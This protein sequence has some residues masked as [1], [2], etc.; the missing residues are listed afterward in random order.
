MRPQAK[1]IPIDSVFHSTV[2]EYGPGFVGRAREL[3]E[4][5][6]WF[7]HPGQK[8]AFIAGE[9]GSGIIATT[10]YFTKGAREFRQEVV[11]QMELADYVELQKW[12][13]GLNAPHTPKVK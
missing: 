10:S 6:D 1:R 7:S 5:R 12:L 13:S 2:P 4:L 8:V 9:Y 3:K 11:H